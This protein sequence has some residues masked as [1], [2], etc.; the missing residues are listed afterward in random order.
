MLSAKQK[1]ELD[2][3]TED[4]FGTLATVLDIQIQKLRPE[5]DGVYIFEFL[6][7]LEETVKILERKV[8]ELDYLQKNYD[9]VKKS[10]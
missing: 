9:I 2:K 1:S 4:Y 7:I 6:K 5:T 10:K 3:K 8:E